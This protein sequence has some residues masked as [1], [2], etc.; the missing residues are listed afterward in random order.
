MCQCSAPA[1]LTSPG[2]RVLLLALS[3]PSASFLLLLLHEPPFAD[4]HFFLVLCLS[5][6]SISLA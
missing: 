4:S 2:T 1:G 5:L 6:L 3:S